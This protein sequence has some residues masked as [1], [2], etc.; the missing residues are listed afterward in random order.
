MLFVGHARRWK[1]R[2]EE[3]AEPEDGL[4]GPAIPAE[5][6]EANAGFEARRR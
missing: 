6:A 4:Q 1:H 3:T 5:V 2:S